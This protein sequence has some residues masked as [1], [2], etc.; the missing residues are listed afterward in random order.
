MDDKETLA[1]WWSAWAFYAN[2]HLRLAGHSVTISEKSNEA[3]GKVEEPSIHEGFT[4]QKLA[5]QGGFSDLIAINEEI[6][7]RNK[8][9]VKL[10]DECVR[11]H[12]VPNNRYKTGR[13]GKSSND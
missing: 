9:H 12:F 6:K 10:D 4:A 3:L 8:A 7:A 13:I 1:R 2:Q 5:K 11:F